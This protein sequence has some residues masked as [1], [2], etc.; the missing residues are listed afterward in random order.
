MGDFALNPGKGSSL[1]R[2]GT[3]QFSFRSGGH[4]LAGDQL[5][6]AL[7]WSA[8]TA[9][10]KEESDHPLLR[11]LWGWRRKAWTTSAQCGAHTGRLPVTD[12]V[13]W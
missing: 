4:T 7:A 5:C 11:P 8:S 10:G 12:R 13:D 3:Q 9:A 2:K 6:F 1:E